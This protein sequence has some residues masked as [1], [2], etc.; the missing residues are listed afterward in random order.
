M[1]LR[2]GEL[3]FNVTDLGNGEP[4]LVFLYY[5]G[6]SAHTGSAVPEAAYECAGFVRNR[7][8]INYIQSE[9]D[10]ALM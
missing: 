5:F 6:G 3:S 10:L 9:L 4:A 1:K 8:A 7:C 2:A